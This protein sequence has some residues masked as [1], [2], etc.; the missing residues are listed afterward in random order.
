MPDELT[1]GFLG[2]GEAGFEIAKGLHTAGLAHICACHRRRDDPA[3]SAWVRERARKGGAKYSG[4]VKEVIE[5]ADVI[6]SVVSPQACLAVA[7][8][9][10]PH[11]RPGQFYLDLTSSSPEDM[12][13]IAALVEP[14]GAKF[15]DGAI[16]G[17]VPLAG[18][19]VL[20]YAAGPH[21]EEAARLLNAWG[22]N[23]Q[24]VGGEPGEASAIKLILSVATKGWGALLVEM[25]LAARHFQVEEPVLKALHQFFALGLETVINRCVGSDALHAARRVEEMESCVRFLQSLGI[26]PMMTQAT[27][28]RLQWS[29]SLGLQDYFKGV[30][31]KGYKEVIAAWES[32]GL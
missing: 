19:R 24:A 12:S 30:S 15:V 31:P 7:R 22:M 17:A 21:S 20:I 2:F 18:H 5:E 23:V 11:L 6:L 4:S 8:D 26:E 1:I 13:H 16:M 3:R 32:L 25:L 9:A 29:A 28:K 14:T 27:V 10:A